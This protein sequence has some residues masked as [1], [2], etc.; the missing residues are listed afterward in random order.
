MSSFMNTFY[1]LLDIFTII[2]FSLTYSLIVMTPI[3]VPLAFFACI[4]RRVFRSRL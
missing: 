3:L 1:G 4:L 2:F